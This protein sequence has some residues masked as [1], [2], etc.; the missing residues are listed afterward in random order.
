MEFSPGW[1]VGWFFVPVAGLFMPYRVLKE[2]W[3]AS[4][5][6]SIRAWQQGPGSPVL[7]V[8]FATC[9]ATGVIHYSQLRVL[10]GNMKLTDILFLGTD[11]WVDVLVEFFCGRLVWDVVA[12]AEGVLTVV[13]FV[14]ITARRNV[15][16]FRST[17][18]HAKRLRRSPDIFNIVPAVIRLTLARCRNK[19]LILARLAVSTDVW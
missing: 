8:W 19:R 16:E 9:V 18:W 7:G 15:A 6:H 1:S 4:H 2:L 14:S 13:L 12:T 3:K 17:N 10:F 11:R 5:W